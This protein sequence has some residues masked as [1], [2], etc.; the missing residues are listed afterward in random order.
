MNGGLSLNHDTCGIP[1]IHILKGECKRHQQQGEHSGHDAAIPEQPDSLSGEPGADHCT[2]RH[3]EQ[4]QAENHKLSIT[5]L[6]LHPRCKTLP[7]KWRQDC[8]AR[9]EEH[10][11][12]LQSRGQL[13]CRLLLETQ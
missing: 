12:E 8:R 6:T 7:G 11:S 2:R 4:N 10:T 13:V 9:S 5:E 1:T 3:I